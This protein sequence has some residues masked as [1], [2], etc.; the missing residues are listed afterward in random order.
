MLVGMS[1]NLTFISTGP[2]KF[3]EYDMKNSWSLPDSFWTLK[4]CCRFALLKS[5]CM[6]VCLINRAVSS[7]LTDVGV[8]CIGRKRHWRMEIYWRGNQW[9]SCQA[10][11]CS[12]QSPSQDYWKVLMALDYCLGHFY[13]WR[14]F[15]TLM[16]VSV[17][18]RV[19]SLRHAFCIVCGFYCQKW[20]YSPFFF[21]YMAIT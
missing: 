12:S 6:A 11:A 16:C 8:R 17:H 9:L 21:L 19:H 5:F 3:L 1:V 4:P 14:A 20:K 10:D 7:S 2:Q 15:C 13:P 18:V